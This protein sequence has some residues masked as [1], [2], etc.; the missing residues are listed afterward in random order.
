MPWFIT[1]IVSWIIFYFMVDVQQLRRTIFGGIFTV[2]LGSLVD[3]GGQH[4]HLYQF[5]DLIIPWAGC[6]IFYK[7]GPIFVIGVLFT[8][9]LPRKRSLQIINILVVSLLYLATEALI[10]QTGVANYLN[11]HILAS[12]IV[13]LAAITS[14]TWLAQTFQLAPSSMKSFF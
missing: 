10:L 11:W 13:D 1:A 2:A 8:Q 9:Y 7:F 3:W 5:R 12:F 6:S 14:L 4:L